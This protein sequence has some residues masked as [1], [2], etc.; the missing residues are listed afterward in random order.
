MYLSCHHFGRQN[1]LEV[2]A[3]YVAEIICCLFFVAC[4]HYQKPPNESPF[5]V[6]QGY[7]S[8]QRIVLQGFALVPTPLG[9][10][11]TIYFGYDR[12]KDL[13]TDPVTGLRTGIDL[14]EFKLMRS[15]GT[16]AWE[17]FLMFVDDD[18]DGMADR[19]FLD[20]NFDGDLD[21]IHNIDSKRLKMDDINFQE[22]SPWLKHSDPFQHN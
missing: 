11:P 13:R 3:I 4:A 1:R 18:F 8:Q 17:P 7:N 2:P 15:N 16:W 20:R 6:P 5:T 14:I 22:L 21:R 19:I 12:N 10:K 9:G